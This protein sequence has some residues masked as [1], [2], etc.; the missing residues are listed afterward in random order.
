MDAGNMQDAFSVL[1]NTNDAS[2]ST[3]QKSVFEKSDYESERGESFGSVFEMVFG[4]LACAEE[5]EK[6]SLIWEMGETDISGFSDGGKTEKIEKNGFLSF[7]LSGQPEKGKNGRE[8]NKPVF[9]GLPADN[10][11][12]N[13]FESSGKN[14]GA[15]ALQK[16]KFIKITEKINLDSSAGESGIQ[17]NGEKSYAEFSE[18]IGKAALDFKSELSAKMSNLKTADGKSINAAYPSN[19]L[20]FMEKAVEDFVSELSSKIKDLKISA[21]SP[22]TPVKNADQLTKLIEKTTQDLLARLSAE[23]QKPKFSAPA[24]NS[25]HIPLADFAGSIEKNAQS[26]VFESSAAIKKES[27]AQKKKRIPFDRKIQSHMISQNNHIKGDAGHYSGLAGEKSGLN[28]VSEHNSKFGSGPQFSFDLKSAD[29][30]NAQGVSLKPDTIINQSAS[31]PQVYSAVQGEKDLAG[32]IYPSIVNMAMRGEKRLTLT[33]QPK[34]LGNLRIELQGEKDMMTLRF[35]AQSE[36]V[37]NII[38][39]SLPDL[40]QD[41]LKEGLILQRADVNVSDQ[42]KGFHQADQNSE[43][44]FRQNSGSSRENNGQ[45]SLDK[46]ITEKAGKARYFGYNSIEIQA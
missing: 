17:T 4:P 19:D 2:K 42:E 30:Q 14:R 31:S 46:D 36:E 35:S 24:N 25:Q 29:F 38:E 40:K 6:N 22:G 15:S 32:Q 37:K 23:I 18:I 8:N 11:G 10:Y 7:G 21:D 3:S 34:D 5:S 26:M 41:L 43:K 9:S 28:A 44:Q 1:M 12:K 16:T 39:Q 13:I 27:G 20:N 33:L 45:A